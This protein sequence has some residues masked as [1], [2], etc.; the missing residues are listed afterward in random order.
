MSILKYFM[1]KGVEAVL[2][3]PKGP[4][5]NKVPSANKE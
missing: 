5:S 2:P 4:L 3:D 1:R